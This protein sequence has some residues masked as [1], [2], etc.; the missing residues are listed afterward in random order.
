MLARGCTKLV[1][2]ALN[3][4]MLELKSTLTHNTSTWSSTPSMTSLGSQFTQCEHRCCC[5]CC[6]YK[7]DHVLRY[8]QRPSPSVDELYMVLII[9]DGHMITRDE[10]GQNLLTFVLR[11]RENPRKTL[12]RKF[13]RPGIE[14]ASAGREVT[15]L[16]LDHSGVLW[17]TW[18]S[19]PKNG[20]S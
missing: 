13:I 9:Y 16:P 4:M 11:L 17:T 2:A 8:D 5:C 19:I 20:L 7:D 18:L 1:T 14:P 6:L 12:T 15:T 3:G 10:C